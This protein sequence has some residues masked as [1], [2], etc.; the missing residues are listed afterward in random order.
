MEYETRIFHTDELLFII[1]K[2][3]NEYYLLDVF[4]NPY[5][6]FM[7]GFRQILFPIK[8]RK[9]TNS[10]LNEF[11]NKEKN[12]AKIK[13]IPAFASLI[14]GI[15]VCF[16]NYTDDWFSKLDALYISSKIL[17]ILCILFFSL[18]QLYFIYKRKSSKFSKLTFS[19]AEFKLVAAKKGGWFIHVFGVF[20][21]FFMCLYY[22]IHF[23]WRKLTIFFFLHVY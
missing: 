19:D 16:A 18:L 2:C 9:L 6:L 13:N 15:S 23:L 7:G 3:E 22:Y 1:Y 11:L 12:V 21:V 20:Q 4:E 17:I 8:G 10:E 14:G 5:L